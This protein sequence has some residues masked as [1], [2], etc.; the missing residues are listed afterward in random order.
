MKP[1]MEGGGC[2]CIRG[3]LLMTDLKIGKLF[4]FNNVF[5]YK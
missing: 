5:L 3:A 4:I 1:M 2:V